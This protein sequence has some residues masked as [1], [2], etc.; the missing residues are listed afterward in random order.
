M[1]LPLRALFSMSRSTRLLECL[2]FLLF[3]FCDDDDG[4]DAGN[5]DDVD[6]DDGDDGNLDGDFLSCFD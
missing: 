6:D 4:N 2:S 3:I 1:P 5:D